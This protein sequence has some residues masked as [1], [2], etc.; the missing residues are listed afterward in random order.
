[1]MRSL[2]NYQQGSILGKLIVD[3][4]RIDWGAVKVDDDAFTKIAK[5]RGGWMLAGP[6]VIASRIKVHFGGNP[7]RARC[8]MRL[9]KDASL[10][11]IGAWMMLKVF[12]HRIGQTIAAKQK[13]HDTGGASAVVGERASNV[14]LGSMEYPQHESLISL[15]SGAAMHDAPMPS[16]AT[17]AWMGVGYGKFWSLIARWEADGA[18]ARTRRRVRLAGEVENPAL[19]HQQWGMMP[20]KAGGL[21]YAQASNLYRSTTDYRGP[22]ADMRREI[23]GYGM[24]AGRMLGKAR[25]QRIVT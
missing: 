21:W 15:G 17:A 23:G 6:K 25:K 1:M 16:K 10:D 13:K 24:S 8:T 14:G 7:P 2:E 5:E 19:F 3:T 20:F 4:R 11:E 22:N 9:R 12:E 18:I